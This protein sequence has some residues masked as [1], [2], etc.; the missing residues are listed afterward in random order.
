MMERID[1]TNNVSLHGALDVAKRTVSRY[2]HRTEKP[3]SYFLGCSQGGRQGIGAA[4]Q[5]PEDYDGIV[6]G[7]PA[8][9]F[10]NL[11][12]WRARFYTITGAKGSH[13]FIDS[14]RWKGL[15]HDEVLRQCDHLDGLVD[16]IIEQPDLCAFDPESLRCQVSSSSPCLTSLEIEKVRA[17][18][19]P[20]LHS[21]GDLIFPGM[22]PGSEVLAANGLYSGSPFPYSVVSSTYTIG[23]FG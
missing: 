14:G 10:N 18:F 9:D 3:K 11:V 7:A 8:I 15:I 23:G 19:A 21:N 4:Q 20:Y 17:V 22:I 12:S 5:Y 1:S 13:D 2:Y 6:A 16:G